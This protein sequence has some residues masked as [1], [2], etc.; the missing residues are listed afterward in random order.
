[1]NVLWRSKILKKE[2]SV[3]IGILKMKANYMLETVGVMTCEEREGVARLVI[4]ILV[5][6]DNYCGFQYLDEADKSRI[7]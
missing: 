4:D 1:M 5:E 2:N 7:S 6:T 3:S